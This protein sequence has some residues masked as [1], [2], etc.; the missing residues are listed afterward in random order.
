VSSL[1]YCVSCIII[2]VTP[3]VTGA[4]IGRFVS[5]VMSAVPSV[6]VSGS[7]E[8]MFNTK[9]RVWIMFIW[10]CFTTLGLLLGPMYGSYIS[11]TVGW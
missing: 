2:G 1:V 4:V 9:Q 5:G 8:D 10:A 7:V 11:I 6:I 3:S